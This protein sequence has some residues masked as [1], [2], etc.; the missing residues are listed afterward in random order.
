MRAR[1]HGRLGDPSA[2]V[3]RSASGG[4]SRKGRCVDPKSSSAFGHSTK[5]DVVSPTC[6]PVL[7]REAPPLAEHRL[8]L[9]GGPRHTVAL[10]AQAFGHVFDDPGRFDPARSTRDMRNPCG[11]SGTEGSLV[12]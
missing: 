4:V 6:L 8:A 3:R 1:K 12:R 11:T 10:I 2:P 5:L 7:S 9:V